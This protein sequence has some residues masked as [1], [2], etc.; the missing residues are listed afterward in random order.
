M[1]KNLIIKLIKDFI[2]SEM[3]DENILKFRN[4]Y[5]DLIDNSRESLFLELGSDQYNILDDIYMLLEMYEEDEIIRKSDKH[6]IN[7]NVLYSGIMEKY[8]EL[9][10]NFG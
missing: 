1:N 5:D 3:S 6:C 10:R 4:E 7:N 9:L 2:S 8:E